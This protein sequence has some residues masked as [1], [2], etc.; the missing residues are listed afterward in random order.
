MR[1]RTPAKRLLV[2]DGEN[3]CHDTW[4]S[5]SSGTSDD[6]TGKRGRG[7]EQEN[8]YKEDE[9]A[10]T[11]LASARALALSE[12]QG[13]GGK[14]NVGHATQEKGDGGRREDSDDDDET[15]MGD[16][17]ADDSGDLSAIMRVASSGEAAEQARV[18]RKTAKNALEAE[19][20]LQDVTERLWDFAQHVD[21]IEKHT[22]A[23]RC[24]SLFQDQAVNQ[25]P[26]SDAE[27]Q[28]E[29]S[30][31]ATVSYE[32]KTKPES[33]KGKSAGSPMR[34][35]LDSSRDL[36]SQND[37]KGSVNYTSANVEKTAAGEQDLV[38]LDLPSCKTQ[39]AH[40]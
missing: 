3:T 31:G 12:L 23:L 13:V 8:L 9:Q 32:R 10:P 28:E 37:L 39:Q 30:G 25:I 34:S 5:A 19:S 22:V 6:E 4:D 20:E 33:A 7:R 29:D 1:T 27:V 21:R 35:S 26:L 36:L 2:F 40:F 24:G 15:F 14:A 17:S 16:D 18:R 11:L 38:A